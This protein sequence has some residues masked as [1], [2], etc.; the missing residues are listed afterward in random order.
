[1]KIKKLMI[2]N[3]NYINNLKSETLELEVNDADEYSC[4]FTLCDIH[5][6]DF[7]FFIQAQGAELKFLDENDD[8]IYGAFIYSIN[9]TVIAVGSN[10]II[11]EVEI[12]T[13]SYT[14]NC[15][16]IS[17]R[18]V[19]SPSQ[20]DP[21]LNKMEIEIYNF[22][23]KYLSSKGYIVKKENIATGLH[24]KEISS[25]DVN[26]LTTFSAIMDFLA[27]AT[28]SH[29]YISKEKIFYVD[30]GIQKYKIH[31]DPFVFIDNANSV[32]AKN[33]HFLEEDF[34]IEISN[35]DYFNRLIL[36]GASAGNHYV[37]DDN[38]LDENGDL[39]YR[40]ENKTEQQR[41]AKINGS[42]GIVER[43]ESNDKLDN[44]ENLKAYGDQLIAKFGV[45]TLKLR[46][47]LIDG[48]IDLNIGDFIYIKHNHKFDTYLNTFKP[49]LADKESLI[50]CVDSVADIDYGGIGTTKK[51]LE[52]SQRDENSVSKSFWD[53]FKADTNPVKLDNQKANLFT[54]TVTVQMARAIMTDVSFLKV[55]GDA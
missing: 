33:R 20:P 7:D 12:D 21:D 37:L 41:L 26:N 14:E 27:D 18:W 50:F 36:H 6:A 43:D 42:D 2:N 48:S 4:S 40:V 38:F 53:I 15:S 29:W 13:Q 55:E 32:I 19:L 28:K 9:S 3:K 8:I 22:A 51:E 16:R 52:L 34:T 54:N 11:Y 35:E 5:Q 31:K 44:V 17:A 49:T 30:R 39:V 1:M 47:T 24:V 46:C 10:E 23:N 45:P 25:D